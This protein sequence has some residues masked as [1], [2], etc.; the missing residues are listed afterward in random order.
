V[1]FVRVNQMLDSGEWQT[2]ATYYFATLNCEPMLPVPAGQNLVVNGGFEVG[3]EGW[4][5]TREINPSDTASFGID[6]SSSRFGQS[7]LGLESSGG[8]LGRLYQDVTART[9]AGRVYKLGGWLKAQNVTGVVVIG[10]DYVNSSGVTPSA[11]SY[12]REV[13]FVSGT[14]DWTY[15]ESGPFLLPP[16][17]S[18]MGNVAL[19]LLVDF[20]VGSGIAWWDEVFLVELY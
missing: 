2:S 1:H 10:L 13:G 19:W 8:N 7:L 9:S 6:P 11:E 4:H 3:L 17:P 16:M 20:N 14:S 18:G 5:S 12:I 15:F